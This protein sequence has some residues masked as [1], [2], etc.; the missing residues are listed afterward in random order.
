MS[1]R[2]NQTH[3]GDEM[4]NHTQYL[5]IGVAEE[6]FAASVERVREI[7]EM[8]PIARLPNAPADFLGVIDVRGENIPVVDLRTRLALAGAADTEDTRIIVLDVALEGETRKL[9]LRADRVFEVTELDGGVLEPPPQIGSRWQ[10]DCIAGIGRR[11]GAFVTVFDID[12]LFTA[13]QVTVAGTEPDLA[14]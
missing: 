14:A 8:R 1:I 12:R 13:D 7:L 11:N 5:T 10:P 3:A 9:G 6:L 4:S 2:R